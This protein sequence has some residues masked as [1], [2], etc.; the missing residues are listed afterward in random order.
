MNKNQTYR[1]L[2]EG[3]GACNDTW[4][5]G[6]NNND[7]VIGPSGAG[8]TRG[9]VLPNILEC[10][11]SMII[12]DSKNSLYRKSAKLLRKEGY[13]V[14]SIDFR[15]GNRSF[16]YNPLDFI[17]H[18]T[19]SDRY[20]EQD[21]LTLSACLVPVESQKEPFWDYAAR[22]FLECLTGY[23]LECLPSKEHTL[24][25][26][27][28]L[29]AEMGG[30]RFK[31]LMEELGELSP[32]SF[33]FRRWEL[34]KG[35][36]QADRMF[37]SVLGMLAEKL[38]MLMFDSAEAIFSKEE[39][40][41]IRLEGIGKKKMAV[42]VNVSDTD[43]AFDRLAPLFYT[44]TLQ[45]LCN[46]ADKNAGGCLSVPVRFL[47]DDFAA[48]ICI[49]DFDKVSSVIRSRGISV[50]IILQS[51]SQLEAAYG[52]AKAMTIINNCDSCLYLGGQDVRSASYMGVKADKTAST[53]LNMPLD[54]AWLFIRGQ[55]PR[56]VE[57]YNVSSHRNYA[58]LLGEG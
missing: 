50:S 54:K 35:M 2:A 40:Q 9:Y 45:V 48:N 11:E 33:A 39:H 56:I 25:S 19:V 44:Q 31:L 51:I 16:G 27:A 20:N 41:R 58:Q 32:K 57:K 55:K 17:R 34:F 26:V 5:S 29:L 7:L 18:D 22:M 13:Q 1:I 49:P 24:S 12:S 10:A 23:V 52:Q 8:K 38:S 42:F 15:D 21:I 14:V 46:S 47:M 28:L 30:I 6:L 36:V 3:E 53:I 37:S 4:R 43:R